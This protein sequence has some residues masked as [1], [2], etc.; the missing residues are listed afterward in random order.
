M[1]FFH[2]SKMLINAF[3]SQPLFSMYIS[4]HFSSILRRPVFLRGCSA[5]FMFLLTGF[6]SQAIIAQTI[7]DPSR[8][9]PTYDQRKSV[10]TTQ[11]SL[12]QSLLLGQSKM[13][14]QGQ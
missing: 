8:L 1:K 12:G 7:T 6:L 13:A 9:D 4:Q 10:S 2:P 3:I 14:T 5:V 11:G